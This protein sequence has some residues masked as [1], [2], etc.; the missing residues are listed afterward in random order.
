[1]YSRKQRRGNHIYIWKGHYFPKFHPNITLKCILLTLLH[2]PL[3][4]YLTPRNKEHERRLD[5]IIKNGEIVDMLQQLGA[6]L[7][8]ERN[9]S[10]Q[11]HG[12]TS[13]RQGAVCIDVKWRRASR[14]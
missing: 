2:W 11:M 7:Q 10:Q 8:R 5:L 13:F 12:E 3:F 14:F 1:M 9:L 6:L 4:Y